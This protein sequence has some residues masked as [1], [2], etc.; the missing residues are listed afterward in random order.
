MEHTS[1]DYT[2]LDFLFPNKPAVLNEDAPVTEPS[3]VINNPPA[4]GPAVEGKPSI[5]CPLCLNAVDAPED[6]NMGY[7]CA[8]CGN[9]FKIDKKTVKEDE[10]PVALTDEMKEWLK[11]NTGTDLIK[12]FNAFGQKF[13]I[14]DPK[15]INTLLLTW[16][17]E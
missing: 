8:K 2:S 15:V 16:I 1:N 9:T 5:H 13:G 6:P 17:N 11:T 4:S 14:T 12:T 10:V 7:K 3:I